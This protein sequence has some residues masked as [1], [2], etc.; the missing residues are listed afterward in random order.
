MTRSGTVPLG[1]YTTHILL[2]AGTAIVS[3]PQQ[4][5]TVLAT[6]INC[7]LATM[8]A[9]RKCARQG[10]GRFAG[11]RKDKKVLFFGGGLLGLYGCALLKEDGFQVSYL[12]HH[13]HPHIVQSSA[14]AHA[15][16]TS[17]PHGKRCPRMVNFA[18][19]W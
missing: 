11:E 2:S 3:L 4:L 5:D 1:C 7:A 17:P 12:Q 10:L 14:F 15:G 6:P 16:E 13:N 8:V 18:P 9:A 19:T